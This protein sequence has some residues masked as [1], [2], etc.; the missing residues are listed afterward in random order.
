[1]GCLGFKELKLKL[2]DAEKDNVKLLAADPA[3]ASSVTAGSTGSDAAAPAAA[4]ATA[5]ATGL[6]AE[7]VIDYAYPCCGRAVVRVCTLLWACVV[8]SAIALGHLRG[9]VALT[10]GLVTLAESP[11]GFATALRSLNAPLSELAISLSAD[12]AVP[13]IEALNST[14]LSVMDLPKLVVDTYL[15]GVRRDRI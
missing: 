13:F 14:V 9:N 4:T 15:G 8:F 12:T 10:E 6:A 3:H 7:G 1:M 2:V 5:T 11:Q